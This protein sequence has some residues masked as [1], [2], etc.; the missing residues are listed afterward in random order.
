[1]RSWMNTPLVWQGPIGRPL[2]FALRVSRH[3]EVLPHHKSISVGQGIEVIGLP[4]PA[5]PDAHEVDIRIPAQVEFIIVARRI[6]VQQ[7]VGHPG[8]PHEVHPV[9]VD[10]KIPA[11]PPVHLGRPGTYR[12]YP[13]QEGGIIRNLPVG[14]STPA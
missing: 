8:A 5:A 13:H 4:D 12:S 6:A 2:E 3:P 14:R 1:M 9:A 10:I 11:Q 7:H